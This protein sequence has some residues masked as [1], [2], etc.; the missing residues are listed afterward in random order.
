LTTYNSYVKLSKIT[1]RMRIRM[2]V[3][4]KYEDKNEDLNTIRTHKS[5]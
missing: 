2:R 5:T 3:Y 4:N 1:I